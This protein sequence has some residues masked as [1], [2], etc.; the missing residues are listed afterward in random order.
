M[1]P[2]SSS[3]KTATAAASTLTS[4]AAASV[5]QLA[6]TSLSWSSSVVFQRSI[7]PLLSFYLPPFL[8]LWR[9]LI[10]HWNFK[11]ILWHFMGLV[12]YRLKKKL[13]TK[14]VALEELEKFKKPGFHVSP[15]ADAATRF[16]AHLSACSLFRSQPHLEPSF[17]A[18]FPLSN[19]SPCLLFLDT[20]L[21]SAPFVLT[22][23]QPHCNSSAFLLS[24]HSGQF[25]Q[26]LGV[27]YSVAPPEVTAR[28]AHLY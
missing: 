26:S 27:R 9:K 5:L 8:Y 6:L 7:E 17:L 10:G 20:R 19:Y 24:G 4:S 13:I 25:N 11:T 14:A 23:L 22:H 21:P 3:N 12:N 16:A 2:P 1:K 18:N 15:T 28:R